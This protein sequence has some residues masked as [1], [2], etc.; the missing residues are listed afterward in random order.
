MKKDESC[1][2]DEEFLEEFGSIR[3]L[4]LGEADQILNRMIREGLD[5]LEMRWRQEDPTNFS[6]EFSEK[7]AE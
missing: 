6:E 2:L 1:W 5:L 4:P 7:K 3:S